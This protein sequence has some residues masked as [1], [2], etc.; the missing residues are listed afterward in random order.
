MKIDPFFYENG[1]RNNLENINIIFLH[2]TNVGLVSL[3]YK[4]TL[5]FL[6]IDTNDP[7][8]VS[9]IDGDEFK[10]NPSVLH[11]NINTLS[12][13]SEKRFI[14]LDLM[15]ISIT[16]NLENIILEAVKTKN[17]SYLLIVKKFSRF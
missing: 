4:K 11:D 16:K 3:I 12:I 13:F 8:R 6:K 7:F 5:E 10:N 9:K 1:L 2:G 17:S 14:L 15:H